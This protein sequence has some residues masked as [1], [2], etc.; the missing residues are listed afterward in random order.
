MTTFY[1]LA[2]N[3]SRLVDASSLSSGDFFLLPEDEK[4]V[5]S[6]NVSD[7][8]SQGEHA[9]QVLRLTGPNAFSVVPTSRSRLARS[10]KVIPLGITKDS[11]D[12]TVFPATNAIKVA[13]EK[14]APGSIALSEDNNPVLAVR[15][16]EPDDQI[17]ASLVYVD[18][19]SWTFDGHPYGALSV[20]SWALRSAGTEGKRD[21]ILVSH[22]IQD[23]VAAQQV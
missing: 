1:P 8:V 4:L 18:L 21:L 2:L 11:V 12:I 23:G 15:W 22:N 3:T 13:E 9:P 16:A 6:V 14:L 5:L 17:N 20:G 7:S 10:R 19:V